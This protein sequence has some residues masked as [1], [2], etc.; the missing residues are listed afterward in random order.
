[1]SHYRLSFLDAL[2]APPAVDFAPRRTMWYGT[3][4][5]M[6]EARK[7]RYAHVYQVLLNRAG[8]TPSDALLDRL[9]VDAQVLVNT[10]RDLH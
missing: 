5:D 7:A 6:V 9:W 10:G 8:S 4:A 2:V 1:M 3:E